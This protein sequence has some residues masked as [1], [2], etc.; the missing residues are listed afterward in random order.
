MPATTVPFPDQLKRLDGDRRRRYAAN[1]A[2]YQG[3]QWENRERRRRLTINYTRAMIDKLTSYLMGRLQFAVPADS[4]PTKARA[5]EQALVAVYED[6]SLAQL[7]FDTEIDCAVL[8]DAAYRVVW[9]SGA[10]RVVVTAPDVQSIFAWPAGQDFNH[11]LRVAHQYPLEGPAGEPVSGRRLTVTEDWTPET[12]TRWLGGEVA[13]SGPNPYGFI[14]YVIYPNI[15]RPKDFWGESDIEQLREAQRELNRAMSQLSRI[16]EVSGNPI[17]ALEGVLESK[18]IAVEPGQ[19]WTMPEN[20]RAYLVDLLAG[21]GV[22]LHIEYLDKVYRALHDLAEMPRT[23]FG[24]NSGRVTSGAALQIE[25]DPLIKKVE[26]KRLIRSSAYRRRNELILRLLSHFT[27]VDHAPYRADVV[28]PSVLPSDRQQLVRDERDLVAA[29][30]H[31]RR[32]AAN[33]LGVEDP[34]GEFKKW[35][36]EEE[37]IRSKMPTR[38][39]NGASA[40]ALR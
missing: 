31:S 2:F 30:L 34:D 7:D 23:A 21:N 19:I 24:D 32:S 37:V 20:S 29:G 3:D 35:I 18:D 25:L 11:L 8:G 14:P 38:T 22:G 26:R 9:D 33:A 39:A 1:L 4:A 40:S 16:L 28:W 36:E 15:R 13:V 5:A 27:G 6:N 17:A 10:E 12:Y